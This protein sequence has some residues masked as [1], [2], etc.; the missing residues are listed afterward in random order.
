MTAAENNP[1]PESARVE[2]IDSETTIAYAPAAVAAPADTEATVVYS[3]HAEAEATVVYSAQTTGSPAAPADVVPPAGPVAAPVPGS[4]AAP[5]TAAAPAPTSIPPGYPPPPAPGP[6]YGPPAAPTS[7][8]GP[9]PVPASYP[10]LG[11][12]APAPPAPGYG[13]TPGYPPPPIPSA[14]PAPGPALQVGYLPP[15]G[16]PP[17]PPGAF[18]APMGGYPQPGGYPPYGGYPL[19]MG[20]PG[21]LWPRFFARLID[22]IGAGFVVGFVAGMLSRAVPASTNFVVLS[23]LSG[24]LT[25]AY[26]VFFESKRGATLGKRMLGLRVLGP[27]GAPAPTVQ[28]SATRN[29]FV[30]LGAIPYVGGVLSLIAAIYLAVTIE[31]SPTKQ[32]KHDQIAGGTQVIKT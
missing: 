14:P 4:V 19:G 7:G 8:Y 31:G 6:G 26:F 3:G 5:A 15:G 13:P 9:P 17:P 16:Y 10:P 18:G 32:G 12:P 22:T 11:Y 1:S 23:V 29:S 27:G 25:Y 24:V 21:D 20:G 28:Q 2:G 30:L